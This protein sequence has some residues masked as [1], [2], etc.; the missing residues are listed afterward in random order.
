VTARRTVGDISSA[1]TS[2]L[3][4]VPCSWSD[5]CGMR[6]AGRTRPVIT[7]RLERVLTALQLFLDGEVVKTHARKT[8]AVKLTACR[9]QCAWPRVRPA[10]FESQTVQERSWV[11]APSRRSGADGCMLI[12]RRATPV[13]L[14]CLLTSSGSA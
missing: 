14:I 2:A 1:V 3:G 10:R 6:V 5:V 8:H 13:S 7:W 9:S 11:T 12:V 4:V